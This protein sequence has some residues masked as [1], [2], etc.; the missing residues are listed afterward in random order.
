[1]NTLS[2]SVFWSLAAILLLSCFP[3]A[4]WGYRSF[5]STDAAVAGF[6]K[7]EIELGYL[8]WKPEKGRNFFT[9]PKVGSIMVIRRLDVYNR[10]DFQLLSGNYPTQVTDTHRGH[11]IRLL[12]KAQSR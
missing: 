4:A 7:M 1:M 12:D 10:F 5:V 3:A 11:F 6:K 9:V 2:N 8:N